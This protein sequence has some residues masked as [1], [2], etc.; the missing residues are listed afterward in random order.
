MFRVHQK[1]ISD[2]ARK[3]PENFART[4]NFVILTIRTRLFN[5]PADMAILDN[6][7]NEESLSGILYGWKVDSIAQI[8]AEKESLYAQAEFI[9]YAAESD[10]DAAEKLL[11]LFTGI[12][13][14]GMAKAGFAAQ[15]IYGVSACL[16]SH[17]IERFGIPA[18]QIKSDRLKKLKSNLRRAAKISQY[19]DFVDKCGGT[20]SLWDS[21]CEYVFN[22]AD[23]TGFKMNGN[24]SF[25]ESAFHV[26]A[27][28]CESLGLTA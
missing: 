5:V 19:C 27:L 22:R 10:R 2:Y 17:N 16:D 28:H 13:G 9:F 23:A 14:L 3:N 18:N 11:N 24:K 6:P 8:D 12:R 20:E 7:E 26:S 25:Y 21:W 15:L 1:T 4:L